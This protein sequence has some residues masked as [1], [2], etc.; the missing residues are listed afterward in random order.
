MNKID[1]D[2]ISANTM[3]YLGQGRI[4]ADEGVAATVSECVDLLEQEAHFRVCR[5][6]YS[7]E[8]K[9]SYYYIP[10]IDILLESEDTN[11]YF[12][13]CDKI[14]VILTTLGAETERYIRKIQMMD[15]AKGMVL[16]TCAGAYLEYLADES[17]KDL[18]ERTFRIC[19]GYGDLSLELNAKLLQ[20]INGTKRIGVTLTPGGLFV[21]QKS[22]LGLIGLGRENKNRSCGRCVRREKCS[23]LAEGIRCWN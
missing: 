15:M 4:P 12:E 14:C 16:D 8:K 1:K 19:P 9:G 5:E 3:K 18:G 7:L 2:I 11:V 21:P 23:F 13:G 20:A 17:E 22:M 6:I 10:E